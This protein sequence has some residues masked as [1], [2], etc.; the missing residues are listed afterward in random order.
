MARTFFYL[1]TANV[2]I[3]SGTALTGLFH[4]TIGGPRH[5][6]LAVFTLLTSCLIQVLVMTY[7]SV[8]GKV[9]SQA[10][11]LAGLD[12]AAISAVAFGKRSVTYCVFVLLAAVVLVTATGAAHWRSGGGG[13]LHLLCAGVLLPVHVAVLVREQHVI[14]GLARCCETTLAAYGEW[15]NS[16]MPARSPCDASDGIAKPRSARGPSQRMG[17]VAD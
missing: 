4:A 14:A 7:C 11:H 15:R 6:A 1:A 16:V 8:I 10:V 13:A 3:L 9:V 5:V 2:L 17:V 12:P